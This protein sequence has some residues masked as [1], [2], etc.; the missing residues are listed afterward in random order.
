MAETTPTGVT[1]DRKH[2]RDVVSRPRIGSS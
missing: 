1:G 2:H